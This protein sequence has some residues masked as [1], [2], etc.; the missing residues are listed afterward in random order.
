MKEETNIIKQDNC[1]THTH[2]H[3]SR[4]QNTRLIL[5]AGFNREVWTTADIYYMLTMSGH[6]IKGEQRRNQTENSCREQKPCDSD[7]NLRERDRNRNITSGAT[8]VRQEIRTHSRSRDNLWHSHNIHITS[9]SS[10]ATEIQTNIRSMERGWCSYNNYIACNWLSRMSDHGRSDYKT[11][12]VTSVATAVRQQ[13]QTLTNIGSMRG[14]WPNCNS[15]ITCSSSEATGLQ[16]HNSPTKK[17]QYS[18]NINFPC[19]CCT[20][21]SDKHHTRSMV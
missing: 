8:A 5:T 13:I 15:P 20:T 9:N 16:A 17:W 1:F 3:F 21:E 6:R 10:E 7:T 19:K 4:S 14:G 2:P 12:T 11:T 18:H